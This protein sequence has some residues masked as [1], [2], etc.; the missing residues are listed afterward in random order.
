MGMARVEWLTWIMQK[1][2][3]LALFISK[4]MNY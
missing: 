1:Q 2:I 4:D 3:N